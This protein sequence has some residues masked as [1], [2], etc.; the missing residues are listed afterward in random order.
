L[1]ARR[2]LSVN[3][4]GAV[5]T[6]LAFEPNVGQS[7]ANVDFLTRGTGYGLFLT[8][9]G[10]ATLSLRGGNAKVDQAAR[11]GPAHAAARRKSRRHR[12]W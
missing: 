9:G 7:D 2:L 1:E 8:D 6:P 12:E 4:V 3:M 5:A 11:G 10:Q